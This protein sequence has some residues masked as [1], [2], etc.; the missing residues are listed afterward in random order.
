LGII[1]VKKSGEL[2]A[3][4]PDVYELRESVRQLHDDYCMTLD[5]GDLQAWPDFFIN[6]CTY[7]VQS[8]ENYELDLPHSPIFC[9]GKG[10]LLDRVSASGVMVYEPRRQRRFVSSLRVST[11]GPHLMSVAT[12]L[13]TEVMIDRDPVVAMTGRYIDTIV[14]I[15]GALKFKDRLCVYDNYRIVQNIIFPI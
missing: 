13:L 3:N 1:S 12:F 6:D 8:I 10:M 14:N 15:E 5:A 9:H 11:D 4:Q 7:R 2:I